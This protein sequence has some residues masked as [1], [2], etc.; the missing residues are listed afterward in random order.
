MAVIACSFHLFASHGTMCSLVHAR[1]GTQDK[2][3]L[4]TPPAVLHMV[5][6]PEQCVRGLHGLLLGLRDGAH[7]ERHAQLLGEELL[8]RRLA[9]VHAH[10]GAPA[11][12]QVPAAAAPKTPF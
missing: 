6:R 4:G 5:H 7:G 1:L 2:A 8:H 10:A 12:R 3:F 11:L 9:Q